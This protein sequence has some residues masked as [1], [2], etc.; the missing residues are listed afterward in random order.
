MEIDIYRHKYFSGDIIQ[1]F[2]LIFVGIS[3]LFDFSYFL[4][5]SY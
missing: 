5:Q 4:P 3:E 2:H 1:I